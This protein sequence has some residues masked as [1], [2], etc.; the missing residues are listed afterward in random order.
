MPLEVYP[1][2]KKLLITLCFS[3]LSVLD[4]GPTFL[5]DL[6]FGSHWNKGLDEGLLTSQTNVSCDCETSGHAFAVTSAL[7]HNATRVMFSI[8]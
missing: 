4:F 3:Q 5:H 2:L 8:A 7:P 1:D 6:M